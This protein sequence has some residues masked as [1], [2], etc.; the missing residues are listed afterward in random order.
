MPAQPEHIQD[1]RPGTDVS[2]YACIADAVSSDTKF[3][4]VMA[5][6]RSESFP[7]YRDTSYRALAHKNSPTR[8]GSKQYEEVKDP[9]LMALMEDP[10]MVL[11]RCPIED[12]RATVAADMNYANSRVA[13]PRN[14]LKDPAV[15]VIKP[16][17]EIQHFVEAAGPKMS[18]KE[19]VG[20]SLLSD[21]D[22]A[23][24]PVMDDQGNQIG[25]DPDEAELGIRITGDGIRHA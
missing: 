6:K 23:G 19:L 21:K 13:A 22:M 4:Y 24:N 1:R 9:A 2:Q 15:S 3:H 25:L 11:M 10:E 14:T 12:Y 17:S 16:E 20:A 8:P 18:P 7:E 5:Q